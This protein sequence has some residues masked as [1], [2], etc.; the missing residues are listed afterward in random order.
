MAA[1]AD[2]ALELERLFTD[3]TQAITQNRTLD[4]FGLTRLQAMTLKNVYSRIGIS[5]SQLAEVTGISRAQLTR[6][7]AVLEKRNLVE[8]RHNADNRRVVNVYGT[9]H[10]KK[11][12][13]EHRQLIAGRIQAHMETLSVTEQTALT[14]HLQ[15]MIRL[16][17]K[18]GIITP[19]D[20]SPLNQVR[21]DNK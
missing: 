5:M 13:H 4:E 18:A 1:N 6:L 20:Q 15:E 16:M 11:V 21:E 17:I 2:N 8:R 14:H 9:E 19:D 3:L 7:I 10:G 12:I